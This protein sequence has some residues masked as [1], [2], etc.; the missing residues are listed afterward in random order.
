MEEREFAQ[1]SE[2]EKRSSSLGH[3]VQVE[4]AQDRGWQIWHIWIENEIRFALNELVDEK[5]S[6]SWADRA[7]W[8]AVLLMRALTRLQI[9][10]LSQRRQER[11]VPFS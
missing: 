7:G 9:L 6:H 2:R 5:N 11:K 4:I 1:K 10:N 8:E 3:Q